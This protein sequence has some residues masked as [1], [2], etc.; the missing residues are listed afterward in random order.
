MHI[1]W[2]GIVVKVTAARRGQ[3]LQVP[4]LQR[5]LSPSP[6]LHLCH[7]PGSRTSNNASAQSLIVP[8][9][10]SRCSPRCIPLHSTPEAWIWAPCLETE[11]VAAQVPIIL[12]HRPDDWRVLAGGYLLPPLVGAALRYGLVGPLLRRHRL[13]QVC[14]TLLLLKTALL[15]ERKSV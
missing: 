1:V 10:S 13:Q 4:H 5:S 12:S 8:D 7:A 14:E 2:Q 9:D 3:Q 11:T 15:A 6:C